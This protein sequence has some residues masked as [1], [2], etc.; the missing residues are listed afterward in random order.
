MLCRSVLDQPRR[1]DL[2]VAPPEALRFWSE[3]MLD[4]HEGGF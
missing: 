2:A 3:F 1:G 4:F